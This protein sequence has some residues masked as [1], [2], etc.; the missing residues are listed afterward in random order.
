MK[1]VGITPT[2]QSR[3]DRRLERARQLRGRRH[4][5]SNDNCAPRRGPGGK[6]LEKW[7]HGCGSTA[8]VRKVQED[9]QRLGGAFFL[10]VCRRHF[11]GQLLGVEIVAV[12]ARAVVREFVHLA[13]GR[14]HGLQDHSQREKP[15]QENAQ[16]REPAAT[17][18]E[19]WH[20]GA[21]Y[22]SSR[23][24]H[25]FTMA[26]PSAAAGHGHTQMNGKR[27]GMEAE[28]GSKREACSGD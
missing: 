3:D 28:G 5:R 6:R 19:G 27:C 26:V 22:L 24:L 17:A 1:G 8:A 20:E 15:K 2:A 18:K 14:H 12:R 16:E 4:K 9:V 11:G 13:S 21:G 23:G 10:F 25:N 7:K